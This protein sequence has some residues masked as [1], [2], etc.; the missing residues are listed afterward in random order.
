[1]ACDGSAVKKSSAAISFILSDLNSNYKNT[2]GGGITTIK[3]TQT[4]VYEVS[5]AQE[6]R[7]DKISYEFE[8]DSACKVKLIHREESTLSFG[9]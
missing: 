8:V 3:L 6:E 5:I 1:M 2:G 4:N 7:I 9:H